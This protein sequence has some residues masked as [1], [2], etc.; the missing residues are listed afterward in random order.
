[1]RAVAL[2]AFPR[3]YSRVT[4][5][6]WASAFSHRAVHSQDAELSASQKG[7]RGDADSPHPVLLPQ[8]HCQN[9]KDQL[10]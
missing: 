7:A 1:M 4:P 2:M 3:L 9:P 10:A 5:K 6:I 8:F